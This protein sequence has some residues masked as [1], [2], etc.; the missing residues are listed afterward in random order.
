MAKIRLGIIGTGGMAN[1]HASEFAK[2]KSVILSACMDID[3]DRATAFA[4][5]H[6]FKRVSTDISDLL[7]QVDAV[8]IVTPDKSHASLTLQALAAGKHVLCEKPLTATLEEARKV[9]SAATAAQARG[10]IHMINFSYRASSAFQKARELVQAGKLGD[11]R[12]VHSHYLQSWLRCNA[13]GSWEDDK[14][15]W[16]LSKKSGSGGALGDIGCHILDLTTGA[17]HDL[18]QVRCIL[19]AS[20][21]ITSDGKSVTTYK[22]F[23]LD[24]NDTALM[25]MKFE[26]GGVGICQATRWATGHLNSLRV[27]IHGTEGAVCFDL[28]KDYHSIDLCLGNAL[29]TCKWTTKQLKPTPT[30]YQRFVRAIKTG[31][32]DQPD[33]IRGAQIQAYMEACIVSDKSGVWESIP[34]WTE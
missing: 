29:Q 20:P 6:G 10:Q 21:K 28:D 17:S 2:E 13:W 24:V 23:D 1:A 4:Q 26:G 25:E 8:A 9:A 12:F 30:N 34:A 15:L 3:A 11:I 33:M 5:K 18:A 19:D 27:E 14:F 31:V 32:H 16:R 7:D 22:G